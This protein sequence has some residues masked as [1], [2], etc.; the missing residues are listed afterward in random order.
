MAITSGRKPARRQVAPHDSSRSTGK[1]RDLGIR[2]GRFGVNLAASA[3][4]PVPRIK[5]TLGSPS[6]GADVVGGLPHV[7]PAVVGSAW[8]KSRGRGRGQGDRLL[9]DSGEDRRSKPPEQP[10]EAWI[11]AEGL[12]VGIPLRW[13]RWR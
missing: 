13:S 3:R 11:M 9:A 12:E 7:L 6:I 2:D 5:P 4:V 8:L 10:D 1:I